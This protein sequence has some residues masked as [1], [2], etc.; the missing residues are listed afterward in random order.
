MEALFPPYILQS[1]SLFNW[2]RERRWNIVDADDKNCLAE[3]T[4]VL[5]FNHGVRQWLYIIAGVLFFGSFFCTSKRKNKETITIPYLFSLYLYKYACHTFCLDAKSIK[6]IKDK[7]M[8]PPVCPA[9]AH[10]QS[11]YFVITPYYRADRTKLLLR[12]VWDSWRRC[13][14]RLH[15]LKRLFLLS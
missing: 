12:V 8:T 5:K 1:R 11:S 4:V 14:F 15:S 3:L 10:Q 7:R 9:N 13:L 6:K 2:R